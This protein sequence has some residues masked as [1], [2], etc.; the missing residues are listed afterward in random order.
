M[1]C[2]SW[3]NCHCIFETN[4][5]IVFLWIRVRVKPHHN[6]QLILTGIWITSKMPF[7]F[8]VAVE[9]HA[10]SGNRWEGRLW[11]DTCRHQSSILEP[12]C[13]CPRWAGVLKTEAMLTRV[14][15][16]M[17]QRWK[18][19]VCWVTPHE[20]GFRSRSRWNRLSAQQKYGVQAD[21]RQWQRHILKIFRPNVKTIEFFKPVL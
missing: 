14:L 16:R 8:I 2:V 18:R 21:A 1:I 9:T 11:Q 15:N 19:S 10:S 12:V 20:F 6:I 4:P 13:A 3:D 5:F 17:F 7:D